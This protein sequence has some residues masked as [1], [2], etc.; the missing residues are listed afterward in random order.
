M[1]RGEISL[2]RLTFQVFLEKLYLPHFKLFFKSDTKCNLLEIGRVSILAKDIIKTLHKFKNIE[3]KYFI[4]EK[5][6]FNKT[7]K[8]LERI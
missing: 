1:T 3:F 2:H 7:T 6:K 5:E 4:L 8:K